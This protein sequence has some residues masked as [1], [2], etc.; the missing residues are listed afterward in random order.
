VDEGKQSQAGPAEQR[1]EWY[2]PV[3][4]AVLLR[5]CNLVIAVAGTNVVVIPPVPTGYIVP[6]ESMERYHAALNSANLVAEHKKTVLSMD[7]ER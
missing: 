4:D 7:A 6:P 5:P 1:E 3:L 2:V